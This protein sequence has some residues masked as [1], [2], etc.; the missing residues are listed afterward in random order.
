MNKLLSLKAAAECLAISPKKLE[1]LVKKGKLPAYKIGGS[2]LRFKKEDIESFKE[3]V[4]KKREPLH[5][6]YIFLDTL[7]DFFYFNSFYIIAVVI[8]IIMIII[9]LRF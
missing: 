5:V 1:R 7:K 4:Y 3:T 8:A 2:Y 9:I 6:K